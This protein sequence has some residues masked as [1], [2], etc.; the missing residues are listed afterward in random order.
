VETEHFWRFD[1]TPDAVRRLA[2]RLRELVESLER[3]TTHCR[4]WGDDFRGIPEHVEPFQHIIDI[5]NLLGLPPGGIDGPIQI[6]NLSRIPVEQWP[7]VDR[8]TL[9]PFISLS[10]DL[11]AVVNRLVATGYKGVPIE[12]G[13][14]VALPANAKVPVP[15]DQLM[16]QVKDVSKR[17]D[18][19]ENLASPTTLTPGRPDPKDLVTLDQAAAIVHRSKRTLERQKTKGGLPAPVIE[20]GVGTPTFTFGRP[21]ELG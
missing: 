5:S 13:C 20:G 17:F 15:S 10:L 1:L 2:P 18:Q 14:G 21:C 19:L 3:L 4:T 8:D 9:R 6:G 11:F 16:Q 12:D 7:G